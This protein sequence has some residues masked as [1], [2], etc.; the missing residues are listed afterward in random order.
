MFFNN[1]CING[2]STNAGFSKPVSTNTIM[3]GQLFNSVMQ[4]LP[5]YS[6]TCLTNHDF[7]PSLM[8]L[9]LI[10]NLNHI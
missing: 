1:L 10:I 7:F 2:T 5:R 4:P 3:N 9:F 8:N 6:N